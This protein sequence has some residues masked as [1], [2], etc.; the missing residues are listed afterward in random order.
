M[1]IQ[2]IDEHLIGLSHSGTLNR[3]RNKYALYERA[4]LKFLAKAK[5]LEVMRNST[6]SQT[7]HDAL[8]NYSLPSDFGTLIDLYPQAR[9]N[10]DQSRRILAEQFDLRKM[11]DNKTI[12][13]EGSEGTKIIRINWKTRS[14]KVLNTMNSYNGNGTFTAVGTAS[15]IATDTIYKYSGSG[16]VRVDLSASGDGIQNTGMTQ[17][18]LSD[19]DEIADVFIPFFVKNSTDLAK[20]NS[21]TAIWGNDVSTAYWTGVAQTTQA[22]GTAF[23][24]GWNVIKVPWS[25]ATET[26]T[27]A[28]ST[29]DSFKLTFN[30]DSAITDI[31]VDNILFSIG[32][33]FDIKYNSAYLFRNTAGTFMSQP[34]SDDDLVNIGTDG[35]PVFLM[36]MLKEMAHQLEGTDSAFDLNFALS[37]IKDLYPS[38]VADNPGQT[39]KATSNYGMS[40]RFQR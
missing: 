35:L 32:S 33:P 20:I 37:E 6:L 8:Y 29:I 34:T 3:I 23:K 39:K 12:S 4:A 30:I 40:P 36:Y 31:R 26:G 14:P 9:N 2:D 22:D 16:S 13:L 5:P 17:V 25:T 18:D 19:E 28:P 1:T 10:Q 24:V 15:G 27:V 21:V 38:F 7:V 11:L